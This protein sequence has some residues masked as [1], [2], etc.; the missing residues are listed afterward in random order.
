[1]NTICDASFYGYVPSTAEE[2]AGLMNATFG[3][4]KSPMPMPEQMQYKFVASLDGNGPC[5]GRIEKLLSGNSVVFKADSDRIEFY[6]EGIKPNVH[7]V[8]IRSNMTDLTEHLEY[9]FKHDDEMKKIASNMYEFSQGNLNFES[10][11]CYMKN[12]FEEYAKL[13]DYTPKPLSVLTVKNIQVRYPHDPLDIVGNKVCT[14]PIFLKRK[15][16]LGQSTKWPI[17]KD[18]ESDQEWS[19]QY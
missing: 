4:L 19:T 17:Y 9:A 7:F 12:L 11:A 10:V 6:Y 13:L 8:P 5:S 2:V 14:Y 3:G 15:E 18:Y 16:I 1:M